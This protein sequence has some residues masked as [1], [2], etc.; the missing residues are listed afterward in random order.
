MYHE[1]RIEL[2]LLKAR[3]NSFDPPPA[4]IIFFFFGLTIKPP[5]RCRTPR[6]RTHGCHSTGRGMFPT[7]DACNGLLPVTTV[8]SRTASCR[9]LLH[10][11]HDT[12]AVTLPCGLGRMAPI[13]GHRRRQ[14]SSGTD[15]GQGRKVPMPQ[16]RHHNIFS[17]LSIVSVYYWHAPLASHP[18]NGIDGHTAGRMTVHGCSR[19]DILMIARQA[20]RHHNDC[21]NSFLYAYTEIII[22]V[23]LYF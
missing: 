20:D 3:L 5:D 19:A 12:C 21:T 17:I 15:K 10:F 22:S 7:E 11:R 6:L 2:R 14:A 18:D 1:N 9:G 8:F 23:V 13:A 4:L 16:L